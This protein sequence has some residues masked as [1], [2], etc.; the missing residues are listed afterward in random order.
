M[1]YFNS[2]CDLFNV[3][4]KSCNLRGFGCIEYPTISKFQAKPRPSFANLYWC[5]YWSTMHK[6]YKSIYGINDVDKTFIQ[7]ADVHD[8]NTR[9]K[10]RFT[11]NEIHIAKDYLDQTVI[12]LRTGASYKM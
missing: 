1:V 10:K 7:N 11:A 12:L 8:Y 5:E 3:L 6:T 4:G 2:R 9:Q